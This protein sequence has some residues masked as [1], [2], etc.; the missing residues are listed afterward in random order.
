MDALPADV[1][2]LVRST[3]R[4]AARS[5]WNDLRFAHPDD[6]FYYFGLATTPQSHR[7]VPTASSYEGLVR[8]VGRYRQQGIELLPDEL[9]WSDLES[10]YAFFGDAHFVGVESVFD[11]LGNPFDRTSEE[12]G[13]LREAMID[14][15]A[16][17]DADGFFG[18]GPGRDGVVVDVTV[19]QGE[20]T[21]SGLA[22]ALRLNPAS[23]LRG[24]APDRSA[25]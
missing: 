2:D 1:Y 7:P 17:L 6:T 10:P 24:Y 22:S 21:V 20:A 5:A 13:H 8:V 4:E 18:E 11:E 3:I 9:R 15:L 16:Q 23:A 19:R 14:A 25:G 12:N